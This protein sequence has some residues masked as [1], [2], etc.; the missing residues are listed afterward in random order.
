MFSPE[1][2]EELFVRAQNLNAPESSCNA[3]SVTQGV[4][5]I[6]F[7]KLPE[8]YLEFLDHYPHFLSV[9]NIILLLIWVFRL[10]FLVR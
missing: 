10:S 1:T 6:L 3:V 2:K 8:K 7:L 9:F 4:Y 5:L